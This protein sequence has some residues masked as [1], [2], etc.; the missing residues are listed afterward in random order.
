MFNNLFFKNHVVY[1]IVNKNL[2]QSKRQQLTVWHIRKIWV[3][4]HDCSMVVWI[5]LF[6]CLVGISTGKPLFLAICIIVFIYFFRPNLG[7]LSLT[8]S[9][10]KESHKSL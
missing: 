9:T 3:N 8:L 1:E 10:Y 4:R 7:F 6:Y 5:V 2:V